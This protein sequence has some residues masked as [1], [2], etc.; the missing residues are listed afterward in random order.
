MKGDFYT[1]N[2][3]TAEKF[4]VNTA[5]LLANRQVL[6]SFHFSDFDEFKWVA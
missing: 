1:T 6:L 3:V 4:V 2:G 5:N